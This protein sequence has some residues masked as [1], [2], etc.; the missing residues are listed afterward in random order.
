[1]PHVLLLTSL[2]HYVITVFVSKPISPTLFNFTYYILVKFVAKG[3]C[4]AKI[5]CQLLYLFIYDMTFSHV[6]CRLGGFCE[7]TPCLIYAQYHFVLCLPMLLFGN[8]TYSIHNW[9][10]L[11]LPC[12]SKSYFKREDETHTTLRS[13]TKAQKYFWVYIPMA[14]PWNP[15]HCL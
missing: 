10:F 15:F 7:V 2:R 14:F 5:W 4:D 3:Q 13:E 11:L 12:E 9:F 1:M 8:K 6:W